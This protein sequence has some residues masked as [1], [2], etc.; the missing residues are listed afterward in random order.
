VIDG[1]DQWA[2]D[3]LEFERWFNGEDETYNPRIEMVQDIIDELPTPHR[4][5]LEAYF[6]ERLSMRD[7]SH[8]F[9]KPG[10]NPSYGHAMV[11][12]AQEV[13]EHEWIERHG[14]L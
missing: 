1:P 12:R 13:F 10:G 9:E 11:K 3:A 4:E 6:Y 14:E 2:L 7:L 8:R 5:V